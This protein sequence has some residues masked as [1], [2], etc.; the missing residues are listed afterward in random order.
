MTTSNN[1]IATNMS[2]TTSK[3][4]TKQIVQQQ[5]MKK[6]PDVDKERP[7]VELYSAEY[8]DQR[9]IP[10]STNVKSYVFNGDELF[11]EGYPYSIELTQTNYEGLEFEK[12]RFFEA[13]EGTLLRVFNI[14][15]KWY[16]S[17]NRRLD[18]FNSKWAAKTTT[19][20]LHFAHA[21][22]ENI[23][24]LSDEEFFEDEEESFEEK[25]KV[26]REYLNKI[27]EANL[28]KS[29]KYM[30]LIEPC[31]EE[32][33][34]CLTNSPRFF[35]I[36]VFDKDNNLSLTEDV[37]LDGFMV[38]KPQELFF[39]DMREMLQA[40]D[41]IDIK[42]I[43]GFIA[44]QSEQG[45]DDKHFKILTNRYKYYF[46]LRGNTS[47]I[48]FRFLELEYQNTLIHLGQGTNQQTTA[49]TNQMLI[50]FCDMYD[51]NA[52]PLLN[53]IWRV[54][55]EDLF[56]KYQIRYIKKNLADPSMSP[57]QDKMLKEIHMH[58]SESVRAGRRRQTD[59]LRIRDILAMQKP[60]YL[61]QLIAEYEKKD[62]DAERERRMREM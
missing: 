46:G 48:R 1:T 17:T 15:G 56:Q 62:K 25:K 14:G 27:Y 26:A 58:F 39:E 54:V 42:R 38:P 44:I 11:F 51:F 9:C 29:K 50:D 5:L 41:N 28:D 34:V 60:S 13:H 36:G 59:R 32:R 20:G 12:C 18:A 37:V 57:K 52:E 35:N 43:Q 47:S 31:K 53:Y 19:F 10:H 2:A 40:L 24:A 21:V 8:R 33:I 16:T 7:S 61:N 3:K 30:F 6:Q 45:R 4:I 49:Q 23:R 55:V 22:R